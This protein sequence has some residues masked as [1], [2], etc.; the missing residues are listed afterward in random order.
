VQVSYPSPQR[1]ELDV[2]LEAPGIVVLADTFYPGWKLTIDGKPA[3]IYRAN[4][5]MRGAAVPA[6]KSR[7]VYTYDPPSFRVGCRLSLAGLAVLVLLAAGGLVRPR[8]GM[9][10]AS[11]KKPKPY[12]DVSLLGRE[13]RDW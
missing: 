9:F 6:G 3:A 10:K 2:T 8:S 4:R 5:L 7:L 12:R 1:V 13:A 11:S